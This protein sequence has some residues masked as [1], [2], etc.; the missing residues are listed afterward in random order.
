MTSNKLA[1]KLELSWQELSDL[2]SIKRIAEAPDRKVRRVVTRTKGDNVE[3][4]MMGKYVS[5]K[6]VAAMMNSLVAFPVFPI[7]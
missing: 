3:D 6:A 5:T 2:D 7:N 1:V 4:R